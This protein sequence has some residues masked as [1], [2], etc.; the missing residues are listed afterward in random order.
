[1]RRR[2]RLK[3]KPQVLAD[4][5]RGAKKEAKKKKAI[6]KPFKK[7]FTK[8]SKSKQKKLSKKGD[9]QTQIGL[10]DKFEG[11]TEE[12]P[13]VKRRLSEGVKKSEIVNAAA[14]AAAAS[15][16]SSSVSASQLGEDTLQGFR[17]NY[18]ETIETFDGSLS[19]AEIIKEILREHPTETH[20]AIINLRTVI[21]QALRWKRCLP[22]VQPFYA[23]KSCPDI[24]IVRTL[25]MLGVNFDCAS[26]GE[27]EMALS[28][29]AK[30]NE[31]I[32]ANPA[33]G[34][35]HLKAARE[36]GV[37]L[38]TFDNLVELEKIIAHY[39]EAE[40]VLR[41]AS[42]DAFSR[43]P[44]G[45]KF[46]ASFAYAQELIHHCVRL[47][48][49]LVGISFH[50]G[51]GAL[52][53]P[54]F[55]D[56]PHSAAKLFDLAK[57]LGNP[58]TLLDI[59]GGYPGDDDGG[60]IF[61]HLARDIAPVIDQ[62]FPPEITVIAEPG[63]YFCNASISMALK[64]YAKREYWSSKT[65]KDEDGNVIQLPPV[66]EVQYYV[67]DGQYGSFN[68][69]M[70]DHSQPVVKPLKEPALDVKLENT[71]FFGP[72]CDSIDVIA[73]NI[74]FPPLQ[75]PSSLP[76]PFSPLF[77]GSSMIKKPRLE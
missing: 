56:T 41:I 9:Q 5:E 45:F 58:L 29:G 63:R 73:K 48:A 54:G 20:F 52:S 12:K 77:L 60:I 74:P 53:S 69:I 15:E 2:H 30:P 39:P 62:L 13:E 8:I 61:D 76:F 37:R 11:T 19:L 18:G 44:F 59:G 75:V 64:V 7:A 70:Y 36:R 4:T 55:I 21:D 14:A 72:T 32:F 28:V 17:D 43:L 26:K 35:D 3:K 10:F 50:V 33:K 31:I 66:R 6:E 27:I 22:R 46:G 51:S 49:N 71:T 16:S 68:S 25:H 23:I 42:N 65:T 67:P 38:M 40:V 24:N 47:K 34:V 1:V 57:L